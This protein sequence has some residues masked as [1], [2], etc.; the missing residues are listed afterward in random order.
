MIV[1]NVRAALAA[2]SLLAAVTAH[3]GSVTLPTTNFSCS[4]NGNDCSGQSGVTESAGN[5]LSF[6][7]TTTLAAATTSGTFLIQ[8]FGPV[9]AAIPVHTL[10]P[11]EYDFTMQAVNEGSG[12]GNWDITFEIFD[13]TTSQ[14]VI[15]NAYSGTYNSIL[16]TISS[17]AGVTM[18][19]GL[20]IAS[21]DN[22]NVNVDLT[23][24]GV[25]ANV[26]TEINV[27]PDASFDFGPVT[28]ASTS[29]PEPA[30]LALLGSG[31]AL[32]ALRRARPSKSSENKE[33]L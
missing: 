10:I 3:A 33:K 18:D 21:G 28:T 19:T 17:G 15:T 8:A 29:T 27:P 31:L 20:A 30:S 32:L 11:L 9:S 12:T 4:L 5:P 6:F 2:I 26:I 16:S 14:P 7:T 25:G 1:N 22:V 23:W 24:S 13:N